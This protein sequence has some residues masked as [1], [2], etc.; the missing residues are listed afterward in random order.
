MVHHELDS[1]IWAQVVTC[2]NATPMSASVQQTGARRS[3]GDSDERKPPS[4]FDLSRTNTEQ[5]SLVTPL[6]HQNVVFFVSK[7][8]YLM[9]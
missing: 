7:K 6:A 2:T 1:I 9:W 4:W 5:I 8:F 3:T